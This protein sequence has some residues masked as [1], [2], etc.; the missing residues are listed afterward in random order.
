MNTVRHSTAWVRLIILAVVALA[1]AACGG[2][3][4]GGA[5]T[6][7]PSTYVANQSNAV[8]LTVDNGPT[9]SGYNVNRLYTSVTICQ[10]GS[11]TLCQTIDHVLVDT[12]STGLRLLNSALSPALNLGTVTAASGQPLLNCIQFV[13]NSHAFGRVA[14]ADVT[15]GPKTATNLPIQIIADPAYTA[16][17]SNCAAGTG[18]NTPSAL[19]ANGI[20]G[21]G[22][23]EQD[24]GAYCANASHSAN[25][26]YFTCTTNACS[27]AVG[28]TAT[29][30]Q[31]VTN[32]VPQFG[33]DNNG[34][35]ID[36][37]AVTA[38][39]ATSIT[40]Q[41]LFGIGTQSNNAVTGASLFKSNAL[42]YITTVL[43]GTTMGNSFIDTGSN[44]LYFGTSSTLRPCTRAT[45]FYC[46]LVSTAL[47]G[48]VSGTNPGSTAVPFVAGNAESL[49]QTGYSVLPTLT[50]PMGDAT[51]FDWGLPFFY[52]RRVF[53][54]IEGYTTPLGTG[55]L[56]AF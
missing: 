43:S 26:Y 20:L 6:P 30:T 34:V 24:C 21:V 52:G 11:T 31:Q 3:G 13:D 7:V 36:L 41:M 54:G 56:Y 45:G 9:G 35:V 50:G 48:T 10:S 17:S 22:I 4:G 53:I 38:P 29:L 42:G 32:P 51:S 18:N 46:P 37:P 12:G 49:F 2:G 55:P 47:T 27:A 15:L 40:G 19:G 25:G 14:T 5:S 44:G 23:Y 33:P 39:G 16:L 8:L 1:M 28:T